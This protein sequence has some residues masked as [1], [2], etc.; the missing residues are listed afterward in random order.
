ML[1]RALNM[2]RVGLGKDRG[3]DNTKVKAEEEDIKW[4]Y[5]VSLV[6]PTRRNL[7]LTRIS[8]LHLRAVSILI[9]HPTCL[10]QPKC[11]VLV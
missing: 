5:L 8:H 3:W 4:V 11:L 10:R 6:N 9:N 7:D 1:V 2:V